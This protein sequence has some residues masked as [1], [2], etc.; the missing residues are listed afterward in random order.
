MD[1]EE[2]FH[3]HLAA[4]EDEGSLLKNLVGRITEIKQASP[5]YTTAFARAVIEEVRNTEGLS[6]DFFA[7]EPARVKMG[8]FGVGSRG[9]GDFF[10][11]REIARI[12]GKT[13]ASVGV[14]EMDDPGAVR[15]GGEYIV[16]TC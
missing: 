16:C 2:Y 14:D 13:S 6:G 1:V 7:F 9:K 15:A 11:H 8:Q 4:G 3:R 10:A 5:A 12:I